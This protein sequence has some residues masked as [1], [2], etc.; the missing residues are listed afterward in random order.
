VVASPR[1][2]L[3]FAL[4]SATENRLEVAVAALKMEPSFWGGLKN[5]SGAFTS[6]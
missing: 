2:A 3:S 1:F 4:L 6:D 5:Q